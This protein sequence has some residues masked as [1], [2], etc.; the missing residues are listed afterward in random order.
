[1]RHGGLREECNPA[2]PRY[3]F[4]GTSPNLPRSF[5]ASPHSSPLLAATPPPGSAAKSPHH[6]GTR[7]AAP[8]AETR[9]Q[10]P[11]KTPGHDQEK[12]GPTPKG[13]ELTVTPHDQ[14]D[15]SH[16]ARADPDDPDAHM[17][18]AAQVAQIIGGRCTAATV[19]R[20]YKHWGLTAYRPGK[21]LRFKETEVR[22]WINKTRV[23]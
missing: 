16:P 5:T 18:D 1:M 9:Q 23:N 13:A 8:A 22:D 15:D 19:K 14:A 3:K 6:P 12:P 11:R 2:G 4:A 21:E 10:P 7:Q 20:R 17:I